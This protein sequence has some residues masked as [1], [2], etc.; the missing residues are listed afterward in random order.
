MPED[1]NLDLWTDEARAYA[2]VT[3][4]GTAVTGSRRGLSHANAMRCA[5]KSGR[6]GKVAIVMHLVGDR[7]YEVDRYPAR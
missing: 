2:V 7:S 4:D 3:V 5:E 1:A 6:H